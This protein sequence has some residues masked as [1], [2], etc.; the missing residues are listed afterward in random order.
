MK[1][2]V[3]IEGWLVIFST[4]PFSKSMVKIS[5]FPSFAKLIIIFFPSE[6][7]RSKRH[8]WKNLQPLL[9]IVSISAKY[10][11]ISKVRKISHHLT[12]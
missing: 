5:E 12:R 6:K 7:S 11:E 1:G 4:I 10:N 2:D 3:S 8:A 9:A